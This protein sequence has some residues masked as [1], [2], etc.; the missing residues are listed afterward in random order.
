MVLTQK[1]QIDIVKMIDIEIKAKYQG[2]YGFIK[3]SQ[4]ER[5]PLKIVAIENISDID[6]TLETSQEEISK[7]KLD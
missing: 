2:K 6:V 5:S 1:I 3:R 4:I 7:L